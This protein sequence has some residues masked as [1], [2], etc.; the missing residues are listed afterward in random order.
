MKPVIHFQYSN[1]TETQEEAEAFKAFYLKTIAILGKE[2][3]V[4][5]RHSP[6]YESVREFDSVV[7]KYRVYARFSVFDDGPGI[8][9]TT[10]IYDDNLF[11]GFGLN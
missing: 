8:H 5:I 11:A 9:D 2:M 1:Y 4:W 7:P 6:S 3:S 10:P